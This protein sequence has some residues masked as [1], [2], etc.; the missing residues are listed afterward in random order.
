MGVK[1]LVENVSIRPLNEQEVLVSWTSEEASYWS[2][3]FVNGLFSLGPFMAESKDRA[4]SI[5]FPVGTTAVIEVHDSFGIDDT[6]PQAVN[7]TPLVKPTIQW[8][9]VPTAIM[10][11][12]YHTI[13]DAGTLESMIAEIPPYMERMSIE[14]PIQLEGR[15]G[16]WHSFRI[17]AVDQY[18][19]ESVGDVIPH[20]AA[21]LPRPPQ[22]AISRDTQSGLLSFRIQ[23]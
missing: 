2:W 18:G 3:V 11:R 13:F 1:M 12:I 23:Q 8:N 14:C 16:R 22:L 9:T 20:H 4:V 5:R 21:D 19:N 10:Y 17:E 7:E 6:V 15:G